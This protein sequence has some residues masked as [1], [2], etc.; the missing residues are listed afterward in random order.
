M[1]KAGVSRLVCL[2]SLGVGDSRN[3]LP[4]FTRYIVVGIFLRHAF[5]DHERQEVVVRESS[6]DWTIARPPHLNDGP[7]TGTYRHGFPPTDRTIQGMIS[8]ADVADFMVKQLTDA[9]YRRQAAGISY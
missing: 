2:S 9:A 8:R 6:L 4:F 3:N 5:A 1:E 7:H